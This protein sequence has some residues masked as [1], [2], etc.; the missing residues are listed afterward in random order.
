M[1]LAKLCIAIVFSFSALCFTYENYSSTEDQNTTAYGNEDYTVERQF[2]DG[3]WWLVYYDEDGI[4][5][6]EVPDPWQ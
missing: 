6:M 5:V 1:T 2:H 4:K 3:L